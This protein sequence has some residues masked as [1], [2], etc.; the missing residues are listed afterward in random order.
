MSCKNT[1]LSALLLAFT[2]PI[3]RRAAA[4]AEGESATGRAARKSEAAGKRSAPAPAPAPALASGGALMPAAREGF[5][6][7]GAP[8]WDGVCVDAR[9]VARSKTCIFG[10]SPLCSQLQEVLLLYLQQ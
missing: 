10:H 3:A 4:S 7:G 2:L 1:A 6:E 8:V 5:E 9:G